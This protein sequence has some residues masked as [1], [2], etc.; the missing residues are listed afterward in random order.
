MLLRS[1][2]CA[3]KFG[4]GTEL[5]H[6]ASARPEVDLKYDLKNNLELKCDVLGDTFAYLVLSFPLSSPNRDRPVLLISKN[7]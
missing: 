5:E 3:L 4:L 7:K 2:T 1:G 6:S